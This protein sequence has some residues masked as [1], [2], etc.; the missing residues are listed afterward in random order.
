MVWSTTPEH[1]K[2]L[3]SMEEDR[4]VDAVNN[5]FVSVKK[6]VSKIEE[7]KNYKNSRQQNYK[8]YV[9]SKKLSMIYFYNIEFYQWN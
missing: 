1:A 6:S 2:Q 4:F 8:R 5:A 3:V 9:L 7:V